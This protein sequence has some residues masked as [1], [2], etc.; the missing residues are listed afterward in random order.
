MLV[1]NAALL[2]P[3][4]EPVIVSYVFGVDEVYVFCLIGLI[5]QNDAA[6][7]ETPPVMFVFM[8][9]VVPK[10]IGSGGLFY[11]AGVLTA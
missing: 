3:A 9:L 10:W 4:H 1:S 6:P 7:P 11:I 2:A 8:L 5:L